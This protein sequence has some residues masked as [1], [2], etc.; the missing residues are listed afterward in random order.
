LTRIS[1][2]GWSYAEF[3]SGRGLEIHVSPF[4]LNRTMPS[5]MRLTG[6]GLGVSEQEDLDTARLRA[7]DFW[8]QENLQKERLHLYVDRAVA[9]SAHRN[10]LLGRGFTV[11]SLTGRNLSL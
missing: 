7:S 6:C 11:F 10:I 2:G 9:Y 5:A 3:S 8:L 4:V 1:R